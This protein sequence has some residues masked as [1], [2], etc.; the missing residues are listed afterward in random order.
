M[1][2]I[3]RTALAAAVLFAAVVLEVSVL[4]TLAAAA[5]LPVGAQPDL[6]LLAVL[7]FAAAWD[8]VAAAGCGFV[9]GL[10]L[11]IA[12]PS[13]TPIGAH[14][15]VLAVLGA[16]GGRVARGARQSAL[17]TMLLAG[18]YAAAALALYAAL[19]SLLGAGRGL[20]APALPAALVGTAVLTALATPLVLPGLAR[21]ARLGSG[22]R[23]SL[24]AP[25]G[26]SAVDAA[27]IRSA[28]SSRRLPV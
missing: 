7:S 14:A 20:T 10:M 4:P 16:L 17:R 9:G 6:V 28:S 25:V 23:V 26:L 11:D 13:L 24:V 12:P 19:I 3:L 8:P 27:P 2:R 22:P 5:R 21:L 15:L 1:T 18:G